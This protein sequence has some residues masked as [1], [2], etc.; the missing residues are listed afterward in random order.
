VL[1]CVIVLAAAA[2]WL[3][4]RPA[5][6]DVLVRWPFATAALSGL[7]AWAWLRPSWLGLAIAVVSLGLWLK[8][9]LSGRSEN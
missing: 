7:A 8:D 4:N 9:T 3:V 6:R 1:S 2:G 5:T